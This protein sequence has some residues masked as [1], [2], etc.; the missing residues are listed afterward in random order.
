MVHGQVRDL[1]EESDAAVHD[2]ADRGKVVER[3]HGVH[4]ELSGAE[5]ALDHDQAGGLEH[6]A[7]DLEHESDHNEVDLA[8]GSNDNTDNDEGD[9]EQDLHVWRGNAHGPGSDEDG[10]WGGGLDS[11]S[12]ALVDFDFGLTLSI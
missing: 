7:A 11:V 12:I 10:N 9:V 3:D 5:E 8:K 2:S 6:D 4:L 1:E